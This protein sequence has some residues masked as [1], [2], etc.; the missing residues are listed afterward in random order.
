MDIFAGSRTFASVTSSNTVSTLFYLPSLYLLCFLLFLCFPT[1]F[2]VLHSV[3]AQGQARYHIIQ[4]LQFPG[5]SNDANLGY[6]TLGIGLLSD[7]CYPEGV[8]L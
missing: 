3:G 2:F 1:F 6:K 4:G 8:A 7:D 5:P